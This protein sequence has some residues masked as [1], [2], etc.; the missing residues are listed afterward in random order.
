MTIKQFKYFMAIYQSRNMTNASKTLFVSRPVLSRALFELESELGLQLFVRTTNGVEPT[1]QGEYLYITLSAIIS[2]F[3]EAVK[4]LRGDETTNEKRP[5]Q[6]GIFDSSGNWFYPSLFM[7]FCDKHPEVQVRVEGILTVD[8]ID[9]LLKGELDCAISPI[10][11]EVPSLISSIHLYN[12]E[13]VLC[14]SPNK[15]RAQITMDELEWLPLAILETLPPPF[16]TCKNKVLS[17]LQQEMLRM[18]VAKGYAYAVLPTD[19]VAEWDD[20][21]CTPFSPRITSS[22]YLLWNKALVQ[23]KAFDTF[24]SFISAFDFKELNDSF[25]CR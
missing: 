12:V 9:A 18:A 10:L 20:V 3:N 4:R 11:D 22:V 2:T 25:T 21:A 6:I 15:K 7:P 13:W 19:L 8:V 14:S 24:L 5:L 23:N 1:E 17:T 16:Y